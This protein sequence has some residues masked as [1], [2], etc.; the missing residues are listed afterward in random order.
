MSERLADYRTANSG[1]YPVKFVLSP[2]MHWDYICSV[3][4]LGKELG[5]VLD[6]STHMGVSIEID[7]NSPGVMVG[8]DGCQFPIHHQ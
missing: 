4:L 5:K 3:C 7:E 2:K 8:R 1:N 6:T